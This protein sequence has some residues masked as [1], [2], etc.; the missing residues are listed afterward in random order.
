MPVDFDE[1]VARR[2][3]VLASRDQNAG[4][5]GVLII[6]NSSLVIAMSCSTVILTDGTRL[7]Y[8]L[9]GSQHLG[10][11][12]PIVLVGGMSSISGDWERLSTALARNRPG[13]LV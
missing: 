10:R 6:C 8:N 12:E 7:A 13:R 9:F 2:G 11:A 5:L 3:V 4:Q 1:L